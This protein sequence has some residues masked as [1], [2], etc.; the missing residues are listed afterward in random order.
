ML[1]GKTRASG[2]RGS[3]GGALRRLRSNRRGSA[4]AMMAAGLIPAIAALGSAIDAGRIYIVKSQLQTGV[5]AA[6]LAGA[7]AFS[8]SGTASN[9][10]ES[11]VAAYFRGNFPDTLWVS[12]T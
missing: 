2:P 10:R 9:S 3:L 7:R 4:I 6:A 12:R 8:V 1:Q 11:Q 5:D